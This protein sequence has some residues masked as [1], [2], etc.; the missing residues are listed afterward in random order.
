MRIFSQNIINYNIPIPENSILRINL[1]WVNSFDDLKE[2]LK[3]HSNSNI[4]L[5]LPIGRTKPPNNK[6]TFEDLISI[7]KINKNI[8]YFAISNVNSPN[9]IQKFIEKIPKHVSIVPK[10]ES[11]DGVKNIKEITSLLGNE[12]I[13]MLDHDDLYSNLIKRNE[14]PEKFKEYVA[15]LSDFCQKNKVTMLRTIGVIFSDEETRST[16][17][18]K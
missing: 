14:K 10:I 12:K 5:D 2:I 8:L 1:A 16:Q 6:Y 17:Y 11:P 3:K 9:D 7:L 4:F 15:I 18:V 13:I